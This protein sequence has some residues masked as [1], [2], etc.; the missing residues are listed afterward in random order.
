MQIMQ[1]GLVNHNPNSYQWPIR[2]KISKT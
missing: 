1:T 2:F